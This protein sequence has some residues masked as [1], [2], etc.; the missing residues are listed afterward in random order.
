MPASPDAPVQVGILVLAYHEV[1]ATLAC[2]RRLL[3][4]E[5]DGVRVLWLEN[6]ADATRAT[7]LAALADS[8]LP[9]DALDPE[10]DALPAA[11]QIGFIGIPENLGYAGGN[12]VGLRFLRRCG[13]A[14]A[15]V[16]NNDTLLTRG[17][18]AE[19]VRAAEARPEVGLWGMRITAEDGPAYLGCRVQA[20]D[21]ATGHLA[22]PLVL[23]RDPMAY[24]SGC[25]MFLR[26]AT[27]EAAGW[28][29]EDYFLYYEDVAFS[30]EIRALGL[31]LAALETVEVLHAESLSSGRRSPLVEYYNRRNRWRFIRDY[32]PQ[33]LAGQRLRLF[34][35]QL[36]KLLVRFRFARIR[37]EWLA[38]RDF[39]AGRMGRTSRTF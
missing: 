24:V 33:C 21:F 18:S 10:L 15:W 30:W 39:R 7:V 25:S 13:V 19:L 31:G 38:Y 11:G 6:D 2:V 20:W 35:Y 4:V 23:E 17:G 9:W 5:G 8:G 27:A 22:D 26:T 32:F 37:L 3:E 1:A 12:N 16:L 36:Q 29:P 34:T 28:I 14:Y